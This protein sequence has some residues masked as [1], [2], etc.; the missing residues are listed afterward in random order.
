MSPAVVDNGIASGSPYQTLR[1]FPP[2][3]NAAQSFM[4]KN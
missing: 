4:E 2:L 3:V 1:K